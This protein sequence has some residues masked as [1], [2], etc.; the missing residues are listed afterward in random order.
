MQPLHHD[1]RRE[2]LQAQIKVIAADI[3]TSSETHTCLAEKEAPEETQ[4]REEEERQRQRGATKEGRWMV[5]M[6][7]KLSLQ[8]V[9]GTQLLLHAVNITTL[10]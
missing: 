3:C 10:S 7:A 2:Y 5:L 6:Y 4:N 8:L 1:N 9:G